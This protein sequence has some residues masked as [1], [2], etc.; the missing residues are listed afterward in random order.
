MSRTFFKGATEYVIATGT[1][2]SLADKDHS[3]KKILDDSKVQKRYNEEVR[4]SK[5]E[6]LVNTMA[7]MRSS[8]VVRKP[9]TLKQVLFQQSTNSFKQ[10]R[11]SNIADMLNKNL[12]IDNSQKH[13]HLDQYNFSPEANATP[14]KPAMS[15]NNVT[16]MLASAP[17]RKNGAFIHIETS[18][19]E[20]SK[21]PRVSMQASTTK[22]SDAVSR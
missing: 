8:K 19:K 11:F 15:A 5:E 6:D 21:L 17:Q 3:L 10:P 4:K 22:Q 16:N 1:D 2:N 14:M 20:L 12:P 9:V 13:V 7:S 18:N